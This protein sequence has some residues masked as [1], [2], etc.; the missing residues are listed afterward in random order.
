MLDISLTTG[1]EGQVCRETLTANILA[2]V[3]NI[4]NMIFPVIVSALFLLSFSIDSMAAESTQAMDNIL[5]GT[6]TSVDISQKI[7]SLTLQADESYLS[8][9]DNEGNIILNDK[10]TVLMCKVA[11][12]LKDLKA[13][14]RAVVMYHEIGGAAVADFIYKPC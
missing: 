9:V 11:K 5:S 4:F 8:D 1:D 10:T 7:N 12:S 6:I 2:T 14:S 3:V 13:G